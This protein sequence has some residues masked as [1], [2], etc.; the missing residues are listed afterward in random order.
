ML[1]N[2]TLYQHL[3]PLRPKRARLETQAMTLLDQLF[4]QEVV[5]MDISL[6]NSTP[7]LDHLTGVYC[8]ALAGIFLGNQARKNKESKKSFLFSYQFLK[9][10]Q[11]QLC[12]NRFDETSGLLFLLDP[13]ESLLPEASYWETVKKQPIA[14]PAFLSLMVWSLEQLIFLGGQLEDDVSELSEYLE[15]LTYSINE[16]LWD[17]EYGI[18]FPK[19][20]S[21]GQII[22]NDSIGGLFPLLA[23]I[24]D[25]EQ[26]EALYRTL[27]NNFVQGQ[28][29]YFPTECVLDGQEIRMVDPLINYLLFHGLLR[30]E[31]TTTA[32]ALRQ[33]TQH[34]VDHFGPQ[35]WYDSKRT[36]AK[37]EAPLT[38][39]SNMERL[40]KHF[41]A[42]DLVHYSNQ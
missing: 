37:L 32:Q 20:L 39:D 33:H 18:Y 23:D 12:K 16:Q 9:Q 30:Y 34:L 29:F 19:N 3:P 8:S 27:A 40:L 4:P 38:P 41:F 35:R 2:S 36:L 42:V 13:K 10:Q 11:L 14:E 22:L 15:V 1:N 26:A 31:F 21:S 25:Q 17:E 6:F 5:K 28:H 7:N 24:P